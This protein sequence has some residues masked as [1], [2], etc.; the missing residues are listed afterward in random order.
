[1]RLLGN[2]VKQQHEKPVFGG[3]EG[4]FKPGKKS[5]SKLIYSTHSFKIIRL[6]SHNIL[7][8]VLDARNTYNRSNIRVPTLK[9]AKLGEL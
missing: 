5:C 3:L 2:V 7:G 8:I 4:V 6:R 9:L 1:M